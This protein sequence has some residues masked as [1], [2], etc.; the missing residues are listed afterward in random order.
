MH[1]TRCLS[2]K[3]LSRSL[4]FAQAGA[5]F[6]ACVKGPVALVG[7]QTTAANQ[8]NSPHSPT[9]HCSHCTLLQTPTNAHWHT[10]SHIPCFLQ[11]CSVGCL[12][13]KRFFS[14]PQKLPEP[15]PTQT[16]K[17]TVPGLID[18]LAFPPSP[19]RLWRMLVPFAS[20]DGLIA[21]LPVFHESIA[22]HWGYGSHHKVN[23]Y[24]V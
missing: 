11:I 5:P 12:G 21:Q 3:V 14:I 16:A 13:T 20:D 23:I 19:S 24:I 10:D 1:A 7:A 9:N 15:L 4:P 2:R 8:H 17:A 22:F 18:A 6:L